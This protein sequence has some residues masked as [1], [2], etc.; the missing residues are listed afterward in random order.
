[1]KLRDLWFYLW[2]LKWRIKTIVCRKWYRAEKA[3][4]LPIKHLI[5]ETFGRW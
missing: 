2:Y 3:K 4:M 5:D 1:M